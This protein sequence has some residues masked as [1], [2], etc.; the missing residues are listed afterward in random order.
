MPSLE[1]IRQDYPEY[2]DMSDAQLAEG[3]YNKFYSDIPREEF[4]TK[5]EFKPEKR[6]GSLLPLSTNPETGKIEFDSDV[7]ILGMLKRAA[8][9]P[10]DV[11]SGEVDPLSEEGLRRSAEAGLMLAPGTS[12]FRGTGAAIAR[13]AGRGK[14]HNF[15]PS[16]PGQLVSQSAENLG[17]AIPRAATSDRMA[18]QRLG[19][20]VTKVP[21]GGGPL[22]KASERAI[23][24]M[25]QAHEGIVRSLGSG[26][27]LSAGEAALAGLVRYIGPK[28]KE[29]VTKAYDLVDDLVDD[30]TLTIARKTEEVAAK[31][32][33]DREASTLQGK[34]AALREVRGAIAAEEGLTYKGIK[35]LRTNIGELMD[36]GI[37][38]PMNMKQSELSR[39]YAA[40]SEDLKI[41]AKNAGGPL[42]LRAFERA[43]KFNRL[44]QARREKLLQITK[45]KSEEQVFE[46]LAAAAS[47]SARGDIK[48]LRQARKAIGKD[49]WPEFVSGVVARL[50]R[51]KE[52]KF[53]AA[54]FVGNQGWSGLTPQGRLELFAGNRQAAK[55]LTDL[56]LVS[57]RFKELARFSNPSGT[58][59]MV[60]GAG[61]VF[62]L[63]HEPMTAI[64]AVLG[65]Q[66]MARALAK[67]R[68]AIEI[69]RWA[70]FYMRAAK[71]PIKPQMKLLEM[72][73]QRLGVVLSRELVVPNLASRLQGALPAA[74]DQE[75]EQPPGVGQ[76]PPQ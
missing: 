55:A 44:I 47:S 6:S 60:I 9:L 23:D 56:A 3:V 70:K 10:R 29:K 51:D 34:S 50:G 22:V 64:T 69:S 48:L 73:T 39:I 27:R 2:D 5:I 31:I 41:A 65:A 72:Q 40:L 63:W 17:V 59:Q 25:G 58:G 26:E 19:Q 45:A 66:L 68:A 62:Y 30:T 52:G 21:F 74:A 11:L 4:N 54:R 42:A 61:Q 49:A 46:R 36:T 35:G 1:E 20:T 32:L 24:Q 8:Q 7:G 71:A 33:A 13:V 15:P 67:P 16:Q 75:Q 53:T 37:G 18:T 12:G 43:N 38:L 57:S 14:P 76:Q 28:T